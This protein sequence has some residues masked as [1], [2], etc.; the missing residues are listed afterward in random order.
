MLGKENIAIPGLLFRRYQEIL[1]GQVNQEKVLQKGFS[2][3]GGD[4]STGWLSLTTRLRQGY[5]FA[6]SG[7]YSDTP[8]SVIGYKVAR[9]VDRL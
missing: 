3:V 7:F 6:T 9:D 8:L 2:L 5:Y 1:P 4:F